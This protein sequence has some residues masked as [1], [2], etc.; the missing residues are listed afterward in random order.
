MKTTQEVRNQALKSLTKYHDELIKQSQSRWFFCKDLKQLFL[1]RIEHELRNIILSEGTPEEKSHAGEHLL[2]IAKEFPLIKLKMGFF[3]R[4]Y[5]DSSTCAYQK[6]KAL[7]TYLFDEDMA[8]NGRYEH[9]RFFV[10][11]HEIRGFGLPRDTKLS[12]PPKT[13]VTEQG[14]VS[15]WHNLAHHEPIVVDKYDAIRII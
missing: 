5:N 7:K 13:V 9:P 1:S 2:V 8:H 6:L 14:Q 15:N 10:R 4:N 11:I 3:S 12:Y